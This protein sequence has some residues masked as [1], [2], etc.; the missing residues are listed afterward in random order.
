MSHPDDSVSADSDLVQFPKECVSE[1]DKKKY[2]GK[3][4]LIVEAS[5]KKLETTNDNAT[6]K[7]VR[8]VGRRGTM[9]VKSQLSA[10]Q[11][12]GDQQEVS[13]IVARWKPAVTDE[14]DV[15]GCYIFSDPT[16][17]RW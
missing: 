13:C 4:L 3:L 12:G 11:S 14:F 1:E 5:L 8:A 10:L 2:L 9:D 16:Y 15:I 17:G 6:E 7:P